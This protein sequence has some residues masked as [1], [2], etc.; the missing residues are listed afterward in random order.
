MIS[1][2]EFSNKIA[3]VVFLAIA[4]AE[5]PQSVNAFLSGAPKLGGS[6]KVAPGLGSKPQLDL[7]SRPVVEDAVERR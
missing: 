2:N 6:N 5:H 3:F 4:V 7:E 1:M